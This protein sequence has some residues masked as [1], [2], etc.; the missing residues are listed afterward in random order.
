[1]NRSDPVIKVNRLENEGQQ[2]MGRVEASGRKENLEETFDPESMLMEAFCL[3]SVAVDAG[4]L[5]SNKKSKQNECSAQHYQYQVF[6]I[7]RLY[8]LANLSVPL[9]YSFFSFRDYVS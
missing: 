3:V 7:L 9:S 4:M 1:M 2:C 5:E 8:Q 6:S